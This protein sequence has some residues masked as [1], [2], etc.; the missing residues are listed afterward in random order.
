VTVREYRKGESTGVADLWRANPTPGASLLGIDPDSV[1][2]VL[3]QTERPLVRFVV[4]LSRLVG[5]P[6]FVVLVVDLDGRVM[7]TTLLNFLP[8]AAYVNGVVVDSTV[9]HRGLAREMLAAAEAL[10]RRY[11]RR[12]AVLDVTAD[13]A[14]ALRLYT[15]WGYRPLRDAHWMSRGLGPGAPPLP[16]LTGGAT[17]RPLRSS[18]ARSLA[19]ADNAL[20][21]P[22]VRSILRRTPSEFRTRA[23][24]RGMLE[25]EVESWVVELGGRPAGMLRATVSG[26]MEAANLSSPVFRG[27]VPESAMRDLLGTALRWLEGRKAPRVVT[28]IA[29]HQHRA[30]PVLD[31][32]GFQEEFLLHTLVHDLPA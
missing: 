19:D 32:L 13:N 21:P 6:I 27:D 15:Q 26:L 2:R 9:R 18:D 8:D 1:A 31:A 20:M 30:R 4:G 10:C 17:I 5:R 11:R 7:G 14:P 29:E 23:A 3:R 24:L 22:E 16:P 25:S 12:F 28:E